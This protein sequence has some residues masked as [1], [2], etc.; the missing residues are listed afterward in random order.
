MISAFALYKSFTPERLAAGQARYAKSGN[1]KAEIAYFQSK[2]ASVETV[3]AFLKDY[4]LLKFALTAHGMESQLQYPA[5]IKTVLKDDPSSATALVN[6]MSDTSY[7]TINA[8]FDFFKSGV[9][10]LKDPAFVANLVEKYT[11][12][13]YEQSLGELN[14][15]L[16]DALYFKKK[17]GAVKNGYEIIG[18]KT[19]FNII[20]TAFNIPK[21]AV[22]GDL[23]LL[24][25]KIEK[26]VDMTKLGDSAYVNK[27]T[28]RF[29]VLS[30]V[31]QQKSEGNPLLDLLA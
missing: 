1:V 20:R 19:M 4:R 18:D 13:T 12:A 31:E 10:K 11:G 27:I 16:T 28:E 8:A 30:D 14:P 9:A 24:K 3:D 29:L 17:I 23:A 2:A 5:R 25:A 22:A 26:V 6:K 15:A 7:R 21:G